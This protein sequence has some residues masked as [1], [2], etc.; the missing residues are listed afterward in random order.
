MLT[1]DHFHVGLLHMAQIIGS[2]YHEM[3]PHKQSVELIDIDH[4]YSMYHS[5]TMDPTQT[6]HY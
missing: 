5:V 6:Y 4:P 3:T 1:S 2:V